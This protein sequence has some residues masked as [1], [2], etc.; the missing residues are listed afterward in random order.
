MFKI[1]F[2][3]AEKLQQAMKD[4]QGDTEEAI[5]DVLHNYA[6]DRAQEDIIRLMPV[7]RKKN[8]SHAK[9]SKSLKNVLGNL[10]V[11]VTTAGKYGYLYFPDDGTSTRL[12][13][14]NQRF[15]ERGGDAAMNDIVERCVTR[16]TNEFEKGV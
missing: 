3:D 1:D 7:S 16:L 14:G 12:H 9:H 4:Y 6:G 11:T 5:N 15:F 13:A 8:G 2:S 10:S